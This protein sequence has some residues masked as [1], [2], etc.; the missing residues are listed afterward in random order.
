MAKP[1]ERARPGP[2]IVEP[3]SLEAGI[4]RV[5]TPA[6][7]ETEE[8]HVALL[9]YA[10]I[11]PRRRSFATLHRALGRPEST[12]RRAATRWS[13]SS[14]IGR[15]GP[16]ADRDAAALYRELYLPTKTWGRSP[17]DRLA[18]SMRPEAWLVL[19]IG[20][21]ESGPRPVDEGNGS[22]ATDD[23]ADSSADNAA[24]RQTS[25]VED[26]ARQ[27]AHAAE[28]AH[29][30][31]VEAAQLRQERAKAEQARL[32]DFYGKAQKLLEGYVASLSR[33]LGAR[34]AAGE[35]I[36]VDVKPRDLPKIL[37]QHQNLSELLGI[38]TPSANVGG[39]ALEPSYRV[40][41]ATATNGDV[42]AAMLEDVA[43]LS[44]ILGS[45][46]DRRDAYLAGTD[47]E[48]SDD[49]GRASDEPGPAGSTDPNGNDTPNGSDTDSSI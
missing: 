42:L 30:R 9:M 47:T 40:Q 25:N 16:G 19:G 18:S 49:A 10:L 22:T 7:S 14:R 20:A 31:A 21:P 29:I 1:R 13:W 45:L 41:L 12:V 2:K 6:I 8:D 26:Q 23:D 24:D 11:D 39:A 46:R 34:N 5:R 35:L 36:P 28:Q 44:V 4:E 37:E 48:G 15:A 3:S 17:L 33:Q 32:T 27:R 43:E 38:I